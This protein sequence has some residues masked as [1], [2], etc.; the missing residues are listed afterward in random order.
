MIRSDMNEETIDSFFSDVNQ[1][2]WDLE[3]ET[4]LLSADSDLYLQAQVARLELLRLRAVILR[5]KDEL[6]NKRKANPDLR[7]SGI[8]S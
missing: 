7:A 5:E 8:Y 3:A 2:I 6:R 4:E 1:Q